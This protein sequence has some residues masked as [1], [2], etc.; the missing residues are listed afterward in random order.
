[1]VRNV[2]VVSRDLWKRGNSIL[3]SNVYKAGKILVS[4]A[5]AAIVPVNRLASLFFG[6]TL[7]LI[8]L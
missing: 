7:N 6:K 1:M 8:I 5:G 2:I 4:A 3:F